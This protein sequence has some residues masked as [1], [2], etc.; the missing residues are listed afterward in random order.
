MLITSVNFVTT[1]VLHVLMMPPHVPNVMETESIS[2]IVT[3][4]LDIMKSLTKLIVQP[5]QMHVKNVQAMKLAQFARPITIYTTTLVQ[6]HAQMDIGPTQ[7]QILVTH[8]KVL[9][10]HAQV[11]IIT[12]VSPVLLE[13]S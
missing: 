11:N 8:V 5:A 13:D 2:T 7:L 12:T 3:V 1:N 10:K 9:V 6:Q 4:Q